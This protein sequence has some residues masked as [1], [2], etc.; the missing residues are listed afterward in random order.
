M[1]LFRL[2]LS[3]SKTLLIS[4]LIVIAAWL[5]G[6]GFDGLSN[7][8]RIVCVC[9]LGFALGCTHGY[10][11]DTVVSCVFDVAMSELKASVRRFKTELEF[12][13]TE[14]VGP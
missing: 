10:L 5:L 11:E 1:N 2:K 13:T 9:S 14:E 6:M 3:M 8:Q 7:V 12:E 4:L